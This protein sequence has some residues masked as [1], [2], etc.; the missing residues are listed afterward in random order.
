MPKIPYLWA[1]Q[2]LILLNL[3]NACAK[4]VPFLISR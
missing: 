2:A 1:S 3:F 4:Y